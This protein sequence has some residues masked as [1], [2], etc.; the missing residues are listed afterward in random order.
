MKNPISER[1]KIIFAYISGFEL[2]KLLKR[3]LT[4]DELIRKAAWKADML[5]HPG[6]TVVYAGDKEFPPSGLR[7]PPDLLSFPTEIRKDYSP[8]KNK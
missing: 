8:P 1:D 4:I 7:A 3:E 2:G 5:L 6:T